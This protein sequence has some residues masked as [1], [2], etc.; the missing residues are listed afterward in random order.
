MSLSTRALWRSLISRRSCRISYRSFS[1]FNFD[2]L[3]VV[4]N[5]DLCA[6]VG[7]YHS[8]VWDVDL[9]DFAVFELFCFAQNVLDGDVVAFDFGVDDVSKLGFS[10]EDNVEFTHEI[11]QIPERA[12][13]GKNGFWN[14]LFW[15]HG[16]FPILCLVT[17]AGGWDSHPLPT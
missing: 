7:E 1:V 15:F 9:D 3:L 11:S 8:C 12:V 4:S 10:V 14:K 17:W 16:G 6:C 2:S 5:S 13:A